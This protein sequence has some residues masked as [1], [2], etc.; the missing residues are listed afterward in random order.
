MKK[1]SL[2]FIFL[3]LSTCV[4]SRPNTPTVDSH[5]SRSVEFKSDQQ[6]K[7]FFEKLVAYLES[8]RANPKAL[9]KESTRKFLET[10]YSSAEEGYQQVIHFL[11]CGKKLPDT[12]ADAILFFS[13]HTSEDQVLTRVGKYRLNEVAQL[14]KTGKGT[15][16]VVNGENPKGE[17]HASLAAKY[18]ISLGVPKETLI[19]EPKGKNTYEQIDLGL[20]LLKERGVRSVIFVASPYHMER[21]LRYYEKQFKGRENE[22]QVYRS[23]YPHLLDDVKPE[24]K[25]SQIL[26]EIF[27]TPRDHFEFGNVL[28]SQLCGT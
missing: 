13:Y 10:T 11:D 6:G 24:E 1:S 9:S 15:T 25:K 22:F 23:S 16:I 4:S 2:I 7:I 28:R 14:Y 8:Y 3:A 27:A 5:S 21:I 26:H 19:L 12:K 20:K 18:L 17:S